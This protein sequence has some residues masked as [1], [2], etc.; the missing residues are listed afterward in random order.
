MPQVSV[1]IDGKTYRMAC[2]DGEED[3]LLALAKRFDRTLQDLKGAFG[4]IGDHRLT[5]MAGIATI[6]R[7]DEAEKRI[8][9]L[10]A[11]VADFAGDD[12]ATDERDLAIALEKAARRIDRLTWKL[13]R[14]GGN[15]AN[16]PAESVRAR[17]AG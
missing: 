14:L 12:A 16:V 6:D 15:E 5:V 10:E 2:G 3:H 17:A 1:D 4:P 11:K 13:N 7:L 8:E 9:A